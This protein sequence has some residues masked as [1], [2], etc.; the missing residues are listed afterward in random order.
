MQINKLSHLALI[1]VNLIYGLNYIIAK[2]VM[3]SD[4]H[5][6]A[7]VFLRIFFAC[8]LFFIMHFFFRMG[9]LSFFALYFIHCFFYFFFH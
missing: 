5:P 3:S 7:F 2:D 9:F 4:I 8:F 1:L 6:S